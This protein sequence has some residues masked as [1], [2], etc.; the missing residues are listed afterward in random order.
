M[1]THLCFDILVAL[2]F[3]ATYLLISKPEIERNRKW[4]QAF[5]QEHE[6]QMKRLENL[7]Q[8]LRQDSELKDLL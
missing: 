1:I 3:T 8:Q 5:K 2:V 7:D 6:K 4:R